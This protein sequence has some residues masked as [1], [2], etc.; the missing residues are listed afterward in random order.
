M[1]LTNKVQ[2]Y[3]CPISKIHG[4]TQEIYINNLGSSGGNLKR[5][6]WEKRMVLVRSKIG[7]DESI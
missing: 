5:N 4:V 6:E 2:S 1:V 3:T 7:P